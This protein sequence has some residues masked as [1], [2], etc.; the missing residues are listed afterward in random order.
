MKIENFE[1][2]V[3]SNE[4][5]SVAVEVMDI[6]DSKFPGST[7]Y[8]VG[9]VVRDLI[10]GKEF[11]DVDI[12][13]NI[14]LN[15]IENIFPTFDIGKNK[16]FSVVVIK[17]KDQI[18]EICHFRTDGEYSDSR[19]P[20]YVK[21][22]QDFKS[23]ANRRDL[24]FNAF[25][26]DRFGNVIDYFN[27][28]EDLKNGIV[29]MVGD[30]YQRLKEDA[31]RLLRVCRFASRLNFQIESQTLKA[32]KDN[33]SD[34]QKIASERIMKEIISMA[35]Q[36]GDRFAD[37][38]IMMKET[39]LLK[40][41]FP[42]VDE[43]DKFDHSEFQHPEGHCFSHCMEA[44]RSS[45]S[46]DPLVNISILFHDIGKIRTHSIDAKGVHHYYKHDMVGVDL[47]EMIAKKLKWDTNMKEVVQFCC[48]NHMIFHN[49]VKLSNATI[50]RLMDSP[51]FEI[52]KQVAYCDS[53]ARL[54]LFD[55][56]DWNAIE[57]RIVRFKETYKDKKVVDG[58]KKVVNGKFIM[59]LR[60]DIKPSPI[61]GDI[62]KNVVDYVLNNN[63]NVVTDMEVIKNFIINYK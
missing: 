30:P 10:L 54:Y 6:L 56:G 60:K 12:S 27:G 40:F 34:I 38:I 19:R 61:L 17:Y 29:R 26:C 41:I 5:L 28:V 32:V 15:E 52:L 3:K 21:E 13:T 49:F 24:S 53:K 33:A 63:L 42:E 43:M 59:D 25:G 45:F 8:L 62:I 55:Q 48:F 35:S 1:D 20:D 16:D 31:L 37:A 11:K 44:L 50:A 47:I 36:S 18:I 46:D 2:K 39:G 57:N 51:Y 7:T 9:G 23:D 58:I 4:Y 14:D 22:V